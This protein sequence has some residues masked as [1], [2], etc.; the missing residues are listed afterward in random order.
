MH[1]GVNKERREE[2]KSRAEAWCAL[3][4]RMAGALEA[5]KKDDGSST[6]D[7]DIFAAAIMS[8][9]TSEGSLSEEEL[10]D[11]E[12]SDAHDDCS[13]EAFERNEKLEAWRAV[14]HRLA[15]VFSEIDCEED[16]GALS[17]VQ[18]SG[19]IASPETDTTKAWCAIGHRMAGVL[20]ACEDDDVSSIKDDDDDIS[21]A[22]VL[23]Q[24]VS[25]STSEVSLSQEELNDDEFI[26]AQD[27]CSWEAL[28]INEKLEA[29]RAIGH[30]LASIFSEID[31]EED[32]VALNSIH[33]IG[34]IGSPE[35]DC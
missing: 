4:H 22:F 17:S 31:C 32:E 16:E 27:D 9:S 14:G 20:Q 3:G 7:D 1:F 29:W 28:E 12:F 15:N 8:A 19:C 25:A 10:S 34:S 21:A 35:T 24:P 13:W 18:R 26:D 2:L 30:R 6:K 11:D 33:R 23:L 5:C